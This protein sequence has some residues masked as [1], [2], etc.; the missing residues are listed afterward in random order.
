M[1]LFGEIFYA[2]FEGYV[3]RPCKWAAVSIGALVGNLEEVLL[4]GLHMWFPFSWAQRTLKV[5]SEGHLEL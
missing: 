5:K 2:K 1:S 4:L 3:K